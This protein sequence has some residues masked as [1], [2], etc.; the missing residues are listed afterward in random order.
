MSR[1]ES[2]AQLRTLYDAP[3][4]RA[5]RKQLCALDAH[6]RRFLSLSPFVAVGT[7]DAEGNADV[8]PR[9]GEPGFVRVLDEGRIAL[10]DRPGNNRLDTYTNILATG[11]VGLLFLLP[12]VDEA[13]RINGTASLHTDPELLDLCREQGRSPK[14]AVVVAVREAYLHCAKA[15]MRAKLWDPASRVPRDVLPTMGRMIADQIGASEPP[16]SQEAMVARYATML[17]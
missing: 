6:C 7:F 9:G 8:S 3:H 2:V 13:L 12:G 14:L 11:R 10:P 15:I 4:D 5:V 17:Y 16:E 1:I